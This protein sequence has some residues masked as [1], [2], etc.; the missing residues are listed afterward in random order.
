MRTLCTICNHEHYAD[1]IAELK[2]KIPRT[3]VA[4]KFN[5]DYTSLG[6]CWSEHRAHDQ[7]YE[8]NAVI[9]PAR[10]H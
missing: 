2:V 7:E 5:V 8:V 1:M 6:R 10:R 4:A 9:K 3:S